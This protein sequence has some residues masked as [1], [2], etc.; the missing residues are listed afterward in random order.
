MVMPNLTPTNYTLKLCY[1]CEY[2][3]DYFNQE[4]DLT[5]YGFAPVGSIGDLIWHY[6][7]MRPALGKVALTN[8][9]KNAHDPYDIILEAKLFATANLSDF[10]VEYHETILKALHQAQTGIIDDTDVTYPKH[11]YLEIGLWDGA[12]FDEFRIYVELLGY[13]VPPVKGT[14]MAVNTAQIH[15]RVVD[16]VWYN[17]YVN[18]YSWTPTNGGSGNI[19]TNNTQDVPLSTYSNRR[20]ER[21]IITLTHGTGDLVNP[22]V[23][24]TKGESFTITGTLTTGH[25]LV[26]MVEGALYEGTSYATQTD[27]TGA[28]FSGDFLGLDAFATDTLTVVNNNPTDPDECTITARVETLRPEF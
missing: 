9:N 25:W 23:S 26:D 15:L 28:K 4:L 17:N 8:P 24:N 6:H 22:T 13:S 5:R 7:E 10:W 16:P 3:C 14:S 27:V 12:A 2:C 11:K 1:Q 18:G 20:M 21:L 19:D